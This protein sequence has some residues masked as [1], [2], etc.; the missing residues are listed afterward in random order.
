ML[1]VQSYPSL[2]FVDVL[3]GEII[4]YGSADDGLSVRMVQPELMA[5]GSRLWDLSAAAPKGDRAVDLGVGEGWYRKVD[6]GFQLDDSFGS[7]TLQRDGAVKIESPE[8]PGFLHCRFG[9]LIAPWDVC[10]AHVVR[11]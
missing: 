8:V 3:R 7:L 11:P 10:R 2:T 6:G 5:M 1:V 9:E 4:D